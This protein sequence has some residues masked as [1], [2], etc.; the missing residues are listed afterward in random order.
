MTNLNVRNAVVT[1]AASGIGAAIATQLAEA[2]A[3]VALVARRQDRLDD[4]AGKLGDHTFGVGIDVTQQE[5][6]ENGVAKIHERLENVDLVVNAAGVMLA[7]PI[8]DGRL[9]DWTRMLDTN[10]TGVLRLIHAFTPDLIKAAGEGRTADLVNIS[11]IGAHAI[12]P[13]YAVYGATKAALTQLSAALRAD[14][15]P[16]DVRVTNVEP[17]LTD[18]ELASHLDDTG[19]DLIASMNEQIGP[20]HADDIADVVTF[21]VSRRRELNL[22]QI[23]AL[24]TRQA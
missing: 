18:T 22:R 21:A 24:P 5:S 20:L 4:L 11:S 16:Y 3:S 19:Q 8:A 6:V 15:S 9:D 14:L 12:F 7:A 17:G 23:I 2:G 10:V 13:G 1:G